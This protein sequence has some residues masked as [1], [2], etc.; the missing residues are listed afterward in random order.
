MS[1]R[2]DVLRSF[3]RAA[4]DRAGERVRTL[5]PVAAAR[6][7]FGELR[8]R[9]IVIPDAALGSAVAH[10]PDVRDA[11]VVSRDGA[12]RIDASFVDG[13]HLGLLLVPERVRFAPHGPKE[14]IFRIEPPELSTNPRVADL[15]AT[16]AGAVAR[17]LWGMM[18]PPEGPAPAPPL[19]EREGP[20]RLRV[21]LRSM[22]ALRKLGGA[23]A[24]ALL[25]DVLGLRALRAEDAGLTLELEL[26]DL[27]V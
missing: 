2:I 10:A 20:G 15:V 5:G 12:L 7:A 17:R 26:P 3:I 19:A 9:R 21:D 1:R 11:S 27:P 14:V 6:R 16:V 22:P 25:L 13:E 8:Q 18:L 4:A 23:H 24:S